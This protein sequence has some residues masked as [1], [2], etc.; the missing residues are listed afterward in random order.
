MFGVVTPL[1]IVIVAIRHSPSAA[2]QSP[3]S[4]LELQLVR[5][6]AV[7][8]VAV[9]LLVVDATLIEAQPPQEVFSAGRAAAA[10]LAAQPGH[11]RVYSPSYSIPQHVAE[12]DGLRLADGVDPLQLR[13]Y[14]GYLTRAAGLEPQGYSVMLPPVA[15]GADVRTALQGVVPDAGML[16]RLGVRYVA[17]AFPIA[18]SALRAAGEFDGVYVYR[19]V[20]QNEEARPVPDPAGDGAI[21]LSDGMALFRYHPWPV[22]AG[23]AASGATAAGLAAMGLVRWRRRR[24]ADG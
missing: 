2:S 19:N 20:Y 11:F 6:A 7:A 5:L 10:W 15:E 3:I 22:Y 23:W 12:L 21:V 13:A 16:G 24:R 17:S 8:L 9:D 4:N 18:D 14:A 1:A